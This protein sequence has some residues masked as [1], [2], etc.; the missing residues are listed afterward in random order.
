[1][2]YNFE[3]NRTL[4]FSWKEKIERKNHIILHTHQVRPLSTERNDAHLLIANFNINF[5]PKIICDYSQK[6]LKDSYELALQTNEG[7]IIP[8]ALQSRLYIKKEKNVKTY[9]DSPAAPALDGI[10]YHFDGFK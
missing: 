2:W 9:G 10:I 1:M 4:I 3:L 7:V 6:N 8:G 5:S